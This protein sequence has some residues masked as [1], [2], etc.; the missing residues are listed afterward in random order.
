MFLWSMIAIL[1][2]G[3]L[4]YVLVSAAK[5]IDDA[6]DECFFIARWIRENEQKKKITNNLIILE[7][8]RK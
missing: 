7:R 8:K 4:G 1:V 5:R 2:I 6:I 3:I